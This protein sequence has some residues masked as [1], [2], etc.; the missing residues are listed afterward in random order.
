MSW[1]EA[2]WIPA[3]TEQPSQGF[4]GLTLVQP[5]IYLH[6]DLGQMQ[7]EH[8]FCLYSATVKPH[9][10]DQ[11]YSK[12]TPFDAAAACKLTGVTRIFF[13]N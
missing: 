5:L 3:G 4:S 11:V 6:N 9:H 2:A 13:L 1:W 10:G 12:G 8:F 7:P